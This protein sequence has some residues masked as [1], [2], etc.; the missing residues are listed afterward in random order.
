MNKIKLFSAIVSSLLLLSIVTTISVIYRPCSDCNNIPNNNGNNHTS[1]VWDAVFFTL[2]NG[3][4]FTVKNYSGSNLLLE[5]S[6]STCSECSIQ[7]AELRLLHDYILSN[8]LNVVILTLLIDLDSSKE[9]LT[10]YIDNNLSWFIGM[11]NQ[12]NYS[13]ILLTSVPTFY[14]FNTTS[15]EINSGIGTMSLETLKS[16]IS[17]SMNYILL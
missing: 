7:N 11:I 5:F 15:Q 3:S 1:S 16:F 17:S 10:Y 9:L 12:G 2:I 6:E 8:S 14:F 4:I 13:K